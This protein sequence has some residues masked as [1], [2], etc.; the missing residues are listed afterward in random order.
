MVA[1]TDHNSTRNVRT[2]VEEGRRVGIY[3]LPG[4]EINT[5][6]EVHCLAYFTNLSALDSFQEYLDEH[7]PEI[8]NNPSIFGIQV[9]VD[10]NENIIYEEKRLLIAALSQ[11]L[12][13]V[14]EKI[15]SLGGIVVPAHIDK[16]RHSIFS[17]LGFIPKDLP[18]TALELSKHT[19][20][21]SFKEQHPEL[22]SNVFIQS[23]DAHYPEEIGCA[24]TLLN[25]DSFTDREIRMAFRDKYIQTFISNE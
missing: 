18:Y 13:S 24:Y 22:K 7:L 2:A 19:T 12:E 17:Q 1:I 4:C 20:V 5:Q 9:A 10:I 23:S 6:E 25:M 15:L 21:T 3:V 16:S 14:A 11:D 8:N